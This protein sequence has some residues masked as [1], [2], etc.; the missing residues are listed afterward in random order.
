[1]RLC[2]SP[3]HVPAHTSPKVKGLKLICTTTTSLT[4]CTDK[5]SLAYTPTPSSLLQPL[6]FVPRPLITQDIARIGKDANVDYIHLV[7]DGA[8][9]SADAY[10]CELP[11]CVYVSGLGAG[12]IATDGLTAIDSRQ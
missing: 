11:F 6:S 8:D 7:S 1:M 10:A 3:P 2:T 9:G 12:L 5:H 4:R